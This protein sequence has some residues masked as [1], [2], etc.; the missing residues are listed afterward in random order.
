MK[1][2]LLG[3][4]TFLLTLL[5]HFTTFAQQTTISGTVTDNTG[6]PL[7]GVNIV[8][9]NTN[10]GIQTDFDGRYSITANQGEV[11]L[12]SYVGFADQNITV[13]TNTTVDV[14]ME[15]SADEL[16]EVIV[17]AYGTST[18]QTSSSSISQVNEETIVNR[19]NANL[20]QTLSGQVAGANITANTGQPGA[21]PN[22]RI[23]GVGS[24]N[25]NVEPLYI[26]DGVP[27]DA[28]SFRSLN[29][30][31]I[32]N[33]SVLKDAGATAIYGNRGA[34][35]VVIITTKKGS[36]NS[37]LEV[38]YTGILQFANLQDND[39]DLMNSP[40]QL[41]LERELNTGLGATLT[42]SEISSTPTTNWADFFFDTGLTQ[43]HNLNLSSG[44]SNI[45]QFTSFGYLEQEGILQDSDIQRFNIQSNVTGRSTN[46]KFNFS[47]NIAINF[48]KS[49]EPN[50]IGG[51]GINRNFILGAYQS[52]P[53][54]SP[55]DYVDGAALLSPLSFTNTPL[56]LIDRLATFSRTEDEIQ[57]LG[58]LE[59][60]YEV[61]PGFTAKV[62]MS[63][64]LRD[65][66]R[67]ASEGPLSFNALLFAQGKDPSG[68]VTQTSIRQFSFNQTTS[69]NYNKQFNLH[70][71]DVGLFTEYFK[72]HYETFGFTQEG[73][74][75]AT[76]VPGDGSAF[77]GDNPDNDF[78]VDDVFANLLDSGLFSYFTRM[79]YDYDTRY[80]FTGTL[81]R[82][83]SFR[84]SD[85][86]R[87]GTFYS[88]SARWN[89]GNEEFMENTVFNDLKLR[90]SYGTT[91]NQ[92][93]SNDLGL[94]G[95]YFDAPDLT[96]D[97]FTAGTGYGAQN[98]I[99]LNQ[100]G[101]NTLKWETTSQLNIGLDF[102]LLDQRFRG[103]VDWYD[104]RTSDLF[105]A[106]PVSSITS[107]S[108]LNTN[109]GELK[110][111]GFDL[112]LNYDVFRSINPN[113]FNLNINLVG[114]YNKQEI[115][116]LPTEEGEIINGIAT[117]LR[118]GGILNEYYTYRYAGINSENGNLLFLT[119]DGEETEN[120]NVDTDRVFLDKNIFPDYE[121]GFGFNLD[122]KGFFASAQ[123]RYA[124]GVDRFDF[125]LQ[126]FQDPTSVGQFRS[127]R[128][129]LDAWSPD[130][131]DG[132]LPSLTAGN[133][134][135]GVN[136]DRYLRNA[137]FLRLR[138]AQIGYSFP[139]RFLEGTGFNKIR[140]FANG[141][142][143][144][145]F[146][147]WRGFDPETVVISNLTAANIYPTPRV[148]AIGFEFGF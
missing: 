100:I 60:S 52:V 19:P 104:K 69:L 11:L 25:G 17:T 44:S 65:E 15:A 102:A 131:I 127:S 147:E 96:R 81:R 71:I 148:I 123:F 125:D 111:S 40:E 84:F 135:L 41:R 66:K 13:G 140:I 134:D 82:D 105:L 39:Y 145:T 6:L 9:K 114:N 95:I 132:S 61:L 118:E 24:V 89:I 2:K 74:N 130:N 78:Y 94:P 7:P 8:V 51:T 45:R 29:P 87:W 46:E 139:K 59:A 3:K 27:T 38:N 64:E 31:N 79:D 113:G 80:G 35:G 144:L 90:A 86:N 42:D 32:S 107:V 22:V 143:L 112:S 5:V 121:G 49:N 138:F 98:S 70:T 47:T 28:N 85:S 91:G 10:N 109:S 93:I 14:Q 136:S 73:L 129:L 20:L 122:F 128:D 63:S 72:A 43:N 50:N 68:S 21:P 146:S 30:N 18:K 54:I 124:I 117:S 120:P 36:F 83:A 62:A 53:Y 116:D 126:G 67:I 76:F 133:L 4:L 58:N 23:R 99:F 34:N 141:E 16:E 1:R 77:I 115:L 103:S 48:S 110:N 12:F 26:I 92:Y 56:F 75:P 33:V 88:L 119:A 101:N 55:S 108:T 142:N 97:L 37:A 137:D 57:I 106:S